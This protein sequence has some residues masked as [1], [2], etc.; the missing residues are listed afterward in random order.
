MN[1]P[2]APPV[3]GQLR[4]HD[5]ALENAIASVHQFGSILERLGQHEDAMLIIGM[6]RQLTEYRRREA[7]AEMDRQRLTRVRGT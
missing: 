6:S 1:A 4:A 3:D 7:I 2:A 5:A